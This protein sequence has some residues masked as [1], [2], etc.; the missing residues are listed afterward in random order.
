MAAGIAMMLGDPGYPAARKLL[1]ARAFADSAPAVT[2][3]LTEKE[4]LRM[5]EVLRAAMPGMEPP[6]RHTLEGALA[7]LELNECAGLCAFR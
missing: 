4:K 5:R 7:P 6:A 1:L 3:L 2:R